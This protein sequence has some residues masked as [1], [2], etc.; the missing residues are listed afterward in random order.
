MRLSL[1]KAAHAV[2]SVQGGTKSGYAPV[3][4]TISFEYSIPLFQQR[5]AELQIPRLR[6]G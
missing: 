3:E 4:M 1:L 2:V 6:S 5:S